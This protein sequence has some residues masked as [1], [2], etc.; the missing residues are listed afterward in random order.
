MY[1]YPKRDVELAQGSKGIM[2]ILVIFAQILYTFYLQA[3]HIDWHAFKIILIVNL[4][5]SEIYK[6]V[7]TFQKYDL[8]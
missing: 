2:L 7:K 8:N 3:R 6:K 1:N 5:R 4:H